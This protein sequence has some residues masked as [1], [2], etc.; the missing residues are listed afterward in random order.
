MNGLEL[1]LVNSLEKVFA[2]Q[3][4]G[5]TMR[6]ESLCGLRGE[7]LSIQ[8]AYCW[9]RRERDFAQIEVESPLRQW[10]RV[11]R[12]I[13]VPCGYPCHLERDSGYLRTEPG[14]YPDR[15]EEL[16]AQGAD[17]ISGQWRSLWID[18]EADETCPAGIFPV[19]IR[20]SRR[21][22]VLG[23][24]ALT[25]QILEAVLPKLPIPH[26]EWLHTDGISH[27]YR[28]PVF[29]EEYWRIVENFI[30]DAVKRDIN[31]IYT[32]I[33]TPPL[34]TAVGGERETV[35]LVGVSSEKDGYRFD[36]ERL[37]RWIQLCRRRGVEYLEIS[38]LFSQWGAAYAPK[39]VADEGGKQRRLFGWETRA[40]SPSYRA[41]LE[42]LL[43]PLTALLRE[44]WEPE[45]VYFHIS[46]EPNLSQLEGYRAARSIV[47]PYLKGFKI[48]DAL[49][50][51]EFYKSGAVEIPVC[52]NNHIGPF[53]KDRPKE[54]W[55]YYCTA[56]CRDVSN[57]F[58]ALPSSRNRAY[59][60]QLYRYRI[61]GI[62]HWG[63]NFYNSVYSLYP[64]DPYQ[65]TDA[66][67]AFPSGD[68]FLVYPGREGVPEESI[69]LMVHGEAMADLRALYYLETLIGREALDREIDLSQIVFEHCPDAAFLLDTRRRVNRLIEENWRKGENNGAN[70]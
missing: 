28:V 66:D 59:G 20:F 19:R 34:D 55:S 2:D 53:L 54:L 44:Q 40:D 13:S 29:S 16:S 67:G 50:D 65:T 63:Y 39:V 37:E 62:L 60:L 3:E 48:F 36:F 11:R 26:T 10:I 22:E 64:I 6:A 30:A 18:V 7:T 9:K 27:Y 35:Q 38:H 61:N 32:P 56:Q 42:A 4:P 31:M 8:A 14:L 21:G 51:Y 46:D 45:R 1:V 33:F 43:P 12:V 47:E 69:R 41:F 5:I 25:V 24:A 23:E 70:A 49:S 57:R 68:A 52:A 58:M 17:L 15:L